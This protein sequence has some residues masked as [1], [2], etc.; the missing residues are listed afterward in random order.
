MKKYALKSIFKLSLVITFSIFILSC[1][2]D[3]TNNISVND[4]KITQEQMN[5][6]LN[7]KFKFESYTY[8]MHIDAGASGEMLVG[9]FLH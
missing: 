1:N 5:N 3:E 7:A 6:T 9:I 4:L 8:P 2:N